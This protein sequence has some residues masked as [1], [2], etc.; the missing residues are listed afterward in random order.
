MAQVHFSCF[1]KT[2]RRQRLFVSNNHCS[3]EQLVSERN[4]I[5]VLLT[6]IL[7]LRVYITEIRPDNSKAFGENTILRMASTRR[8][9]SLQLRHILGPE[10]SESD[11]GSDSDSSSDSS[12]SSSEFSGDLNDGDSATAATTSLSAS[13]HSRASFLPSIPKSPSRSVPAEVPRSPG[14]L[15]RSIFTPAR[16]SFANALL[17]P[18]RVKPRL[19][20]SRPGSNQSSPVGN[21]RGFDRRSSAGR[22]S[23]T[24]PQRMSPRKSIIDRAGAGVRRLSLTSPRL[25]SPR[26]RAKDDD[27]NMDDEAE[28]PTVGLTRDEV[29]AALVCKELEMIDT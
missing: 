10:E 29:L 23:L 25:T 16:T 14:R 3:F 24:S 22:S 26:P 20:V 17:S 5:Y 8:R 9:G 4:K 1:W 15:R 2:R 27:R 28:L 6:P 18:L 7:R 19:S 13:W 11:S 21:N 12:S